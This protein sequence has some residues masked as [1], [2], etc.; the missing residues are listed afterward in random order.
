MTGGGKGGQNQQQK[1]KNLAKGNT[2]HRG[3]PGF[4]VDLQK[5]SML[6]FS[7]IAAQFVGKEKVY[8]VSRMA[9]AAGLDMGAEKNERR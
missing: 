1:H 3:A 5:G 4:S 7:R 2:M 6:R 9:G 8:M